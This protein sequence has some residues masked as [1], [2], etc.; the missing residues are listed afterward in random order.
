MPKA[1][2]PRVPGEPVVTMAEAARRLGITRQA[3]Q[4]LVN[5]GELEPVVVLL[6]ARRLRLADVL[7]HQ[8]SAV[9][10]ARGR[11]RGAAKPLDTVVEP[12]GPPTFSA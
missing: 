6:P 2:K 5:R 7:A 1:R 10:Q 12:S 9:H 4:D 11:G 8:P 3:I